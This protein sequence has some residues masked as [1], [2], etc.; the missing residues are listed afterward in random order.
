MTWPRRPS[1]S[2]HS[3]CW[4]HPIDRSER[5]EGVRGMFTPWSWSTQSKESEFGESVFVPIPWSDQNHIM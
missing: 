1:P 5:A 3:C 4:A 2:T